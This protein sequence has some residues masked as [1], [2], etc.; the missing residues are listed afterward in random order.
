MVICN[1]SKVKYAI[2]KS[3][4]R[5]AESV[6]LFSFNREQFPLG[7]WRRPAPFFSFLSI[8]SVSNNIK[9]LDIDGI[10]TPSKRH[11]THPPAKRGCCDFWEYPDFSNGIS[12][13]VLL[14]TDDTDDTDAIIWSQIMNQNLTE[15]APFPEPISF[16]KL[17]DTEWPEEVFIEGGIY[18][19]GDAM[20]I[21]AES[22]AGKSTLITSLIREL[23]IGGNFLGFKIVKPLKVL[24]MQAEIRES[25]LKERIILKYKDLDKEFLL[26]SYAWNTRGL[27]LIERDYEV[28]R[29]YIGKIMPD[30]LIIDPLINFHTY[31]ENSATQMANFFRKLDALKNEFNLSLIMAQH[32]KKQGGNKGGKISLL[33][34][35]RGSSSIRGWA[36]I[37][38]AIEGRT[39]HEYRNLEFDTRNNDKPIK[40]M[41]K[42]N[43]KT[44]EFDWHNPIELIFEMLKKH[45]KKEEMNTNQVIGLMM[46]KCGHLISKNRN[47]AFEVKDTLI[48]DKMMIQR[49]DGVKSFLRVNHAV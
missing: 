14:Y 35:I 11:K 42:Y 8:S 39:T 7:R 16:E 22:K 33:E 48:M 1:T 34:M 31:D 9:C 41:I 21:G 5:G 43:P 13:I 17:L 6:F 18:S 36:D 32:F 4:N 28:V 46:A 45:M 40:R 3:N 2:P 30:I 19:R 47:K 15:I 20:I 37:T 23:I 27:I 29:E 49:E 25:R 24:L 10:D 38:I 12:Y 44:K 26:N